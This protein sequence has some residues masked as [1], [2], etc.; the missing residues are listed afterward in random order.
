M[1]LLINVVAFKIG[2]LA[3]VLGGAGELAW[4]G[5]LIALAIVALHI[6][7]ATNSATEF[8]FIALAGLI[9]L[10]WDSLLASTGWLTYQSGTW[11]AGAAPYWIV[12][13]W[14]LF[15]TTLN[16]SLSWLKGRLVIA[17]LMG[18]VSGP[19]AFYAGHKLGAVTF[20]DFS[21]AMIALAIGWAAILPGLVA[22]SARL[23][24][25][26]KHGL[27]PGAGA[28]AGRPIRDY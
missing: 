1:P 16:V 11:F 6:S 17:S 22:L 24:G 21:S 5:S 27:M 12:A 3:C 8:G 19:L 20:V 15:A 4:L 25:F 18:A 9:G 14:L 28:L 23:D 13:M 7:R 2:W 26:A 10:A